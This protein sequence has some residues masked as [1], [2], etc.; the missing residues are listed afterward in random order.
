MYFTQVLLVGTKSKSLQDIGSFMSKQGFQE[1]NYAFSVGEAKRFLA[2]RQPHVV[3]VNMPLTDDPRLHILQELQCITDA[4]IILI[5]REDIM[6]YLYEE[7]ENIR[8][9]VLQRP[10]NPAIFAKTIKFV[11][12]LIDQDLFV[13]GQGKNTKGESTIEDVM[14]AKKILTEQLHMSEPQAHRYIQ[15]MAMNSRLYKGHL[16][17]M[18]IDAYS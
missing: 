1:V 16:A 5:G 14:L 6:I 13:G 10:L 3:L 8:G 7:L 4:W 12:L 9:I 15:K 11:K 18:I 2:M 17:Q